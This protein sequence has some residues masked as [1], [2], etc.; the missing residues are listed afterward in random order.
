MHG[1][2]NIK[3]RTLMKSAPQRLWQT[4]KHFLHV[5]ASKALQ[6]ENRSFFWQFEVIRF[7]NE[8]TYFSIAPYESAKNMQMHLLMIRTVLRS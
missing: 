2:Q 7:L 1:Q 8:M 6:S 4:L 5:T 3:K